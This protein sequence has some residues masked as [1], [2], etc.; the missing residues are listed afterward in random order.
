MDQKFSWSFFGFVLSI[1]FF[2]FGL[3]TSFVYEKKPK[4]VVQ[5]LSES[6]V[7]SVSEDVSKL[8]IIFEGEDI[9]KKN[10]TLSLVT[11]RIINSGSAN[12]LKS[13]FDT[14]H[15]PILSLSNC[16]I[17]RADLIRASNDYLQA[18]AQFIIASNNTCV[19]INPVIIDPDEFF[20]L[21][22]LLLHQEGE[23]PSVQLSGK[24]AGVSKLQL[25][26]LYSQKDRPS[27]W[28]FAFGGNLVVQ[29]IRFVGYFLGAFLI[30][31]SIAGISAAVLQR[32]EKF[33]R[34]RFIRRFKAAREMEFTDVDERVFTSYVAKGEIFL[35]RLS[36]WL[37]DEKDLPEQ[38]TEAETTPVFP[39]D[40]FVMYSV[41]DSPS[42]PMHLRSPWI[43]RFALDSGLATKTGDKYQIN[44]D[45]VD[46]I[47]QF[48]SFLS[49]ISPK[50]MKVARGSQPSYGTESKQVKDLASVSR[51]QSMNKT[52]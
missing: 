1:V 22:F 44:R 26:S 47:E 13:S 35:V 4:L 29:V 25:V 36:H 52:Q 46:R 34:R 20:D 5:V 27:F 12:I 6:R 17:I 30:L 51:T 2:A 28:K 18:A 10:Q 32:I 38:L 11:F 19:I 31:V 43:A 3:Y 24:V 33:R 50:R 14:E 40:D 23:K 49:L 8:E 21:K 15:L 39:Q 41:G 7:Y 16:R 42:G 9:R 37:S 45:V 48:I